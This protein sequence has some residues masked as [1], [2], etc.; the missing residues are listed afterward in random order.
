[1]EYKRPK[2][3]LTYK[4]AKK[5]YVENSELFE[6]LVSNYTIEH[7]VP[8][9]V[10]HTLNP[11]I[12]SDMHNFMLYPK[13]LNNAR[14]NNKLSDRIR[15]SLDTISDVNAYD[16]E[17]EK[18]EIKTFLDIK[19]NSYSYNQT[20][21]PNEKYRGIISRSIAYFVC[22]YPEYK[23]Y[24][25]K[26]VIN[27]NTLLIWYHTYPISKFEIFMN[28]KIR[29][30]QGNNNIFLL[31]PYLIHDLLKDYVN[32]NM[33]LKFE[34]KNHFCKKDIESW[35]VIDLIILVIYVNFF[36]KLYHFLSE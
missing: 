20:F 27:P 16:S 23:K 17:G 36:Q 18:K 28:N 33:F 12:K 11:E 24:I 7:I 32:T 4:D 34:Y 25:F 15:N 3:L 10:F 21:I 8:Q 5:F 6:P 13:K 14:K 22:T 19:N 1:M 2:K 35:N 29:R 30:I 31:K 9:H 26:Y